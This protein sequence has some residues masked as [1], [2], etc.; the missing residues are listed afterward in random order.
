[1][2]TNPDQP[3]IVPGTHGDTRYYRRAF[4]FGWFWNLQHKPRQQL[5]DCFMQTMQPHESDR[6][7]DLGVAGLPEPLENIFEHYYPF[8]HRIVAVGTEDCSFL[9]Q[10]Y[11]GLRFVRV[12]SG[13][14]LPFVDDEFDIGF[15]NATIEHVGSRAHQAAFM[16]ELSR[17]ARRVF[18][19]TPNRWFPVELHVRLPFV[20]WL[21]PRLFRTLISKLGLEFYAKEENLNLLSAN[22]LLRLVPPG[23]RVI[24]FKRNYFMGLPSN[25]ILILEK[26]HIV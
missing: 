4:N 15:S 10:Q 19:A 25:L 1:M 18:V 9:E 3:Q 8:S 2:K 7:L 17:V 5:I 13:E 12:R 20:H 23:C 14:R 16:Q 22:D 21:P 24:A 11:L 26:D 6:V